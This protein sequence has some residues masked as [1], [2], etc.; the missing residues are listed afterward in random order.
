MSQ[1][2][3]LD[4]AKDH[5]NVWLE[6]ERKVATGQEYRIGSRMLKRA[7]LK[8][9]RDSIQYW[10]REVNRLSGRRNRVYRMVPRD[11]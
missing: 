6:A 10:R 2:L 3:T 8:D 4:R 11:F 5:L 1:G 9:I 7:D